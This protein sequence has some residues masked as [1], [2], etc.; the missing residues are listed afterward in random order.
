MDFPFECKPIGVC[1]SSVMGPVLYVR[2]II[3]ITAGCE[4]GT[5]DKDQVFPMLANTKSVLGK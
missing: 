2:Q 1:D 3:W 4:Y 5:L